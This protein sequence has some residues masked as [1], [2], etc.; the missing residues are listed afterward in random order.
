MLTISALGNLSRQGS[1]AKVAAS[2]YREQS[3]D[4]YAKNPEEKQSGEWIG[5]GAQRF[6]LFEPP[7][8]EQLQSVLAGSLEGERVKNAGKPDRQTGWDLTFSPP[9]SV[10]IAWALANPEQRAKIE[11]AHHATVKE[12]FKYLEPKITTRRGYMGNR[13]E[14]AYIM[15]AMITHHTSRANDPQLHSHVVVPNFAGRTD[16]TVGTIESKAFYEYKMTVGAL[17]QAGLAH[18]LNSLG[19]TIE[20]GQKGTFRLS[21]VD[22]RLEKLFSKRNAQIGKVVKAKEIKTY[23][24]SAKVALTTRP[25]KEATTLSERTAAWR[26][27]AKA[28]GLSTDIVYKKN[29]SAIDKPNSLDILNAATGKLTQSQ[30][31]FREKDVVRELAVASM[32][33]LSAQEILELFKTARREEQ[34]ITLARDKSGKLVFTTREMIDVEKK[35]I[36]HLENLTGKRQHGV[37]PVAALNQRKFLSDEQ[38]H[39]I[40]A[41]CGK[42]AIVIIQGRAGTGKTTM[43]SAVN[44]SYSAAGWQVQGISLAGQAA[45]NLE[46]HTGIKS[47]TIAAWQRQSEGGELAQGQRLNNKTVLVVDE[48]GMV[49]SRQMAAILEKADTAGAKVILIG[50]ERQLQPIEAGG[51]LHS[52][53][54]RLAQLN[55]EAS[56]CMEDIKRQREEW[57]REIVKQAAQGHIEEAL[58]ELDKRGQVEIY[59]SAT[60]AREKLVSD[61]LE[62]NASAQAQK[63]SIILTNHKSDAHT[64]NQAVREKLQEQGRVGENRLEVD[65][66]QNKIALAEGDRIMFT[67]NDYNLDVRN[68]QRGTVIEARERTQTIKVEMDNK[69][70]K[71]INVEKYDHLD[72]G[73]ASTTHKAQGITVDRAYVYMHTQ[74]PMASQ[75]STYVQI[76]RSREETKI[77]AA[78][79]EKSIERP[80]LEKLLSNVKVVKETVQEKERQEAFKELCQACRKDAAKDTTLDYPQEKEYTR[81]QDHSHKQEKDRGLSL[82]M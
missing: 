16:G 69:Q 6:G 24:G 42:S 14:E 5:R 61:Y 70:N 22:E 36:G 54:R 13:K 17:Y 35:M 33:K 41:A 49:G 4:Y 82:S 30:S 79:G 32:G 78:Q 74:E 56:S 50:D 62:K 12:V 44:E 1:A 3:A 10:S 75:Q 31:V 8:R 18:R 66:G 15:G 27:E 55:T 58:K 51:A 34:I 53:D 77:Y 39:S 48:A 25:R 21:G 59:S 23:A 2:Y 29:P 80:E 40:Q 76:S 64:I 46:Q 67:R 7:T 45:Q 52:L 38:K 63:E 20:P 60:Q 81:Q 68:G 47:Q 72:Y 11:E 43:L 26:R 71:T 73:W 19:Y 9:K 28:V 57:M 37:D 65:N